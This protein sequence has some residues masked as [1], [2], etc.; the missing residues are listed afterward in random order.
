[1]LN[2]FLGNSQRAYLCSWNLEVWWQGLGGNLGSRAVLT[3]SW[4]FCPWGTFSVIVL[5]R[6]CSTFGESPGNLWHLID[7]CAG[8][9]TCL[10]MD[11]ALPCSSALRIFSFPRGILKIGE[12][13]EVIPMSWKLMGIPPAPRAPESSLEMTCTA[14]GSPYTVHL[15]I[16]ASWSLAGGRCFCCCPASH[17]LWAL[18]PVSL[19]QDQGAAEM[20]A[21]LPNPH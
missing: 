18:L 11:Q 19:T 7:A 8:R 4:C 12:D 16:W 2:H 15:H 17:G 9:S 21:S 3:V 1:M 20:R 14:W 10:P 13:P 5:I 6:R